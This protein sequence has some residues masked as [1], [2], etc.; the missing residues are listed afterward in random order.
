MCTISKY[1]N[2]PEIFCLFCHIDY[3]HLI[4]NSQ[5]R[6]FFEQIQGTF[7]G[8]LF[9]YV[10][11]LTNTLQQGI[12]VKGV[13]AYAIGMIVNRSTGKR[14]NRF[15]LFVRGISQAEAALSKSGATFLHTGARITINRAADYKPPQQSSTSFSSNNNNNN[16]NNQSAPY[17][18]PNY[19][20]DL[21]TFNE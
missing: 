20:N 11:D 15:F 17:R 2:V 6:T 1:P 7:Q 19:Y 8:I 4:S 21:A 3:P 5:I 9:F 13:K 12:Q 18:T 14:Q 16:N 10:V